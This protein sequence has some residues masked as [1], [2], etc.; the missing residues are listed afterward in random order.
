MAAEVQLLQPVK[1]PKGP[2]TVTSEQQY[3]N[4]FTSEL[5]L[6]PSQHSS[7]VTHISIPP[8]LPSNSLTAPQ[9]LFAVTTGSRVQI[10]SSKTRKVVKTISRFGVDDIARSGN[11]RRDGRILVAGGD[12]GSIQAF[13]VKSRAILKTW[14][15]HKQPVW[16]TEWN[17][18]E[19]TSLMSCSDDRTVRLWDLPSDTSITTFEGHQDYVRT[20]TFMPA[21]S[22]L[23]VSGS[24]D[25]TVRLWDSRAGGKAVMVF[26]H[27]HPIETV[28]PMPSGTAVLATSDNAI[29]VLDI[30]AAKPIHMLRNHQ[31]TVTALS[32]ANNGSRLLSGSLDGHV[33]VF[34]TQGWNVV[35]G[36]KY[37][38]PILSLSVVPSQKEDKHIAVGLSS[39]ILSIRTHLSGEQ[40]ALAR[41]R[42][43]E[44]KALMEGKIDEYDRAKKRK[45]GKG[46]E[47]RVR[48]K[49]FT[50]ESADI[51]I[52]GNARGKVTTGAPWAHALR[53]AQYAKA[54]DMDNNAR[55]QSLSL[56]TALRHR[57]ALRSALANR[58]EITLQPILRWLIKNISD[59]RITRLTTD[60]AL[61][62]LDLYA[63]QLGRSEE[64]DSLVDALMSRASSLKPP[65]L[66]L[67]VRNP[68]LSTWL[69]NAR[70]EPWSKWP[71]FWTGDELG[72]GV[73][74]SVPE[75]SNVYPLLGRPHDSLEQSSEHYTVA[76]PKYKGAKY[77]ASTTNLTYTIPAPPKLASSAG[78]L[79][80]TLSFL[81]PITPTSTLRQSIPAAY[82]SVHV[83]GSFDVDIY[84]DVNGQWVSGKRDSLIEWDLTQQEAAGSAKG[85]KTW[86]VKRQ[87]EQ[88]FTEEHDQAEWG[89]LHFTGPS[90]VRHESGTSALL[91]QRFARTGTLQDE[92]DD[93]F[94]AIM[95]EEPV[96]AF[97]KSFRLKNASSISSKPTGESVLF[98][99]TH[100]Q[101]PVTQYASAR[102][103]TF[104]KPLWK[105]WFP[106]D[107]KVIKF[108]YGDFANA[109]SLA[110]NYSE[111]LRID[112]YQSG[113]TNYVDIVALSARQAM[114]ATSFSGTPESPLLFLKE[115]SSNGNSQTVDVIFPAFPFFL[116]TN[117]RWLAYLLEPLLEHQLSGQYPN[118]YSMHDLGAHFPNL[119]G[120]ADGRDEY[121]P[122]EEC[123][124]MLI[125][126]LALINSMSYSSDADAQ[127]IWSTVGDDTDTTDPN[128]KPFALTSISEHN[129]ISHIDPT[130]GGAAKG[131]KQAKKWLEGSY[132]LWKQWTGY[133]VEDALEPHNQLC[134]D[135]FAGWLPL[136]TNLALKGII[137]IKAFS[138]IATLMD[139]TGDAKHYLNISESYIEKWQDYGIS[140]DGGHAKLAYDWYGSWTTLYSL[141]A[142]AV[143]CFHP[144]VTNSSL[145][146]DSNAERAD[147]FARGDDSAQ[148]PLHPA[149]RKPISKD[150]IPHH[151]Y[152][153]QSNW[154]ASVMQKYGLPLDSRH[155]YTKS[156]WEFEA[157]AVASKKVRSEIL[158]RVATWLNKTVTDRPFTDLYNTE[159]DGGFPGPW[160]FARP[161]VGGHFA[162]LTLER[163]C[164]GTGAKA[165]EYEEE[166]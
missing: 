74:A 141:Y 9:D 112:A 79:E 156:D 95:D 93:K 153:A 32:L 73:L 59:Y 105:S 145:S 20:G 117:P 114:G 53:Q 27:Q 138:E 34:E 19:L 14:K 65:I 132:D 83:Q 50:G 46:W 99:I 36:L 151:V 111:Q 70:E 47:K 37:P 25:Q 16:T 94:R 154:Y 55:T 11:L 140:R 109:N 125:M 26:K 15:E 81:S 44:M 22:G 127:S 1:L 13:D 89:Q 158:D 155:L 30:V 161:V 157:A 21:Q 149:S 56:L 143:L 142:D 152:K 126:G 96:F 57:S 66:P 67:I 23:L 3:W 160:F 128:E 45:R 123:G 120:H 162:F 164:G 124:D 104:M 134:T 41:E 2:S 122:V 60:V 42:E 75:T 121:M 85:L 6:D 98:T 33:K 137:G 92:V 97:S 163:A 78:H 91:R 68:Y 69:Q 100:I 7:P 54:L 48:G 118:K 116:Y 12:S 63:D 58:D 43:K 136:Q 106:E 144:S 101:D 17:P 10:F 119:T 129:G 133:L 61:V 90:D 130:W 135:D 80:I 113:S 159:G 38:S 64:I 72:F 4:S 62:V 51:V 18:S 31:K 5:R 24:Y 110:S 82:L 76:F 8:P 77:D 71:M 39:G 166:E 139:R 86:S 150:F 52:E 88:I 115:I 165:F 84:V 147:G 40:K 29:S 49:D 131:T 87:V 107:D 146:S 108:H 102:G 148:H 28:L 35:G 103:L